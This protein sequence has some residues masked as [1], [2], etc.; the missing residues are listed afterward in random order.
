MAAYF[1]AGARE[2]RRLEG[3]DGPS[4]AACGPVRLPSSSGTGGMRPH[5]S[6]GKCSARR[7]RG[8]PLHQLKGV[9]AEPGPLQLPGPSTF[10]LGQVATHHYC[11]TQATPGW[12]GMERASAAMVKRVNRA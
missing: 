6:G 10:Q 2:L 5:L 3:G 1:I 12:S 7:Q 11:S 9:L 8:L 4:A